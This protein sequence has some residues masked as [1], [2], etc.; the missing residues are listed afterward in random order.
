MASDL[1]QQRGQ[2]TALMLGVVGLAV[3][4]VLAVVPLGRGVSERARAQT[5]ADAAALAGAAAGE[6][7]ARDLAARNGAVLVR[8]RRS[9]PAVWV[10]VTV[11]DVRAVAKAQR[12]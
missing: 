9:G 1:D 5:A 7:A 8:F 10:E 11:G 3:V 4:V 2:A 6:D 12:D